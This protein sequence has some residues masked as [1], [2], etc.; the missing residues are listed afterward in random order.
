MF[1][2]RLFPRRWA[3]ILAWTGAA[4]AWGSVAVASGRAQPGPEENP[5][6]VILPV[7]PIAVTVT[8]VSPIPEQPSRGLVVIRYKPVEPPAPQVIVN[9]VTRTK[10]ASNSGTTPPKVKSS[11]S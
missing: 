2:K 6:D 10:P 1:V 5:E 7:E 4:L 9:T 8:T 3:A 11:G